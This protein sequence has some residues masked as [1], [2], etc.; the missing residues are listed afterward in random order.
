MPVGNSSTSQNRQS[1]ASRFN[2]TLQ[3]TLTIEAEE[4]DADDGTETKRIQLK[5]MF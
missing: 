1:S 5:M 4:P 2:E 3:W